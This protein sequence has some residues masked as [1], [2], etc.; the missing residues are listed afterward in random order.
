V[1]N[2]LHRQVALILVVRAVATE[3]RAPI[4]EHPQQ[5][6]LMRFEAGHPRSFSNSAAVIGV[7]RSYSLANAS[8]VYVSTRV[9]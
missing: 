4:R 9:C 5:R 8:F 2:I 6:A 3:L 1:I 7:L